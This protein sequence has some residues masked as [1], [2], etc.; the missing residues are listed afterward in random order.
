MGPSD[1]RELHVQQDEER[2]TLSKTYSEYWTTSFVH[3]A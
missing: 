2:Q 3:P 1:Q